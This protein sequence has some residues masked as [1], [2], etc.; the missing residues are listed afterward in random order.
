[1]IRIQREMNNTYSDKT[2]LGVINLD[3]PQTPFNVS[4]NN[5]IYMINTDSLRVTYNPLID[6]AN[7]GIKI[8]FH[9]FKLNSLSEKDSANLGGVIG[10]LDNCER[11]FLDSA[12]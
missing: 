12:M 11:S 2:D 4:S 6:L 5:G 10:S 3:F 1:M 8:L 9:Y 7:G